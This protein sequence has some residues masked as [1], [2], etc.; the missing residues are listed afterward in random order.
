LTT[1]HIS[2]VETG[3]LLQFLRKIHS[4]CTAWLQ[5]WPSLQYTW[6]NTRSNSRQ[7]TWD[8]NSDYSKA[9]S[10]IPVDSTWW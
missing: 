8:G 5:L 3:T 1:F 6:L 2:V 7:V 4:A 10:I 9:Y